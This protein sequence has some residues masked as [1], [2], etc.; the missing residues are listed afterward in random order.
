MRL[1]RTILNAG[2]FFCYLHFE[3]YSHCVGV[4]HRLYPCIKFDL[5]ASLGLA[6]PSGPI[7]YLAE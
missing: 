5:E 7:D 1:P 2:D 4:D 6:F 3:S